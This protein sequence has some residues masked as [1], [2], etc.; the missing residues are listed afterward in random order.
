MRYP[1]FK[2]CFF[3]WG[4]L[5]RYSEVFLSGQVAR[6]LSPDGGVC[7]VNVIGGRGALGQV[8]ER[9]RRCFLGGAAVLC[10]DPNYLFWGFKGDGGWRGSQNDNTEGSEGG[11]GGGAPAPS[12][13]LAAAAAHPALEALCPF[14]F[15]LVRDTKRHLEGNDLMGWVTVDE[16]IAMLADPKVL[17]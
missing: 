5:C 8:A 12:E 3:K 10:T 6:C 16:F 13:V 15:A 1:G 14:A 17:V 9:F 4:T 7:V 2:I 11:S